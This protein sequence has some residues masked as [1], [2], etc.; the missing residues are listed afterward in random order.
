MQIKRWAITKIAV[1]SLV[2]YPY[3][4]FASFGS[5]IYC[6]VR[7]YVYYDGKEFD[8]DRQ[9]GCHMIEGNRK[10]EQLIL[11]TAIHWVMIR[12]PRTIRGNTVFWY[13]WGSDHVYIDGKSYDIEWG[14]VLRG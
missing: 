10:G 6:H 3:T 1:L 14:Y 13:K 9:D 12:I 2:L 5:N 7:G 8:V 4:L 11:S